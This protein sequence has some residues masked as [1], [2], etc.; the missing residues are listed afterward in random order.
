MVQNLRK[1]AYSCFHYINK[2][3]ILFKQQWKRKGKGKKYKWVN[4]GMLW[5]CNASTWTRSSTISLSKIMYL[6]Q[7]QGVLVHSY[8]WEIK[9]MIF[10]L[11]QNDI[12]SSSSSSNVTWDSVTVR[13]I[14]A[15]MVTK[16]NPQVGNRAFST[17]SKLNGKET[18]MKKRTNLLMHSF[19]LP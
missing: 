15:T 10:F 18:C 16:Q 1:I 13:L 2:V 7:N 11:W 9:W 17:N 8:H 4:L 12:D 3:Q 19:N 6:P 5:R 14:V